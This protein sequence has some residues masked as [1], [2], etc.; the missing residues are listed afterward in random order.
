MY[1]VED[2]I[3]LACYYHLCML[4]TCMYAF[5]YVCMCVCM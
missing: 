4:N 5:V 1:T 3:E 2:R